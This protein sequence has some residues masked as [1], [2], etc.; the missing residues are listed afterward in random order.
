MRVGRGEARA[1]LRRC[2]AQLGTILVGPGSQSTCNKVCRTGCRAQLGAI[3]PIG[4]RP[5]L[6]EAVGEQGGMRVWVRVGRGEGESRILVM[7]FPLTEH[8]SWSKNHAVREWY[9]AY[10]KFSVQELMQ[11]LNISCTFLRMIETHNF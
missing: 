6:H 3:S 7:M 8:C 10:C 1:G 5:A 9:E 2:G 11:K 4:L